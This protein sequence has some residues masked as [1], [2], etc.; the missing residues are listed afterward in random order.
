M[1]V[2]YK[3]PG[4]GKTT[5]LIKMCEQDYGY[6]VCADMRQV[7]MVQQMAMEMGCKIPYPTTF[8]TFLSG[9]Y[10]APGVKKFYIDDADWLISKLA[11]GNEVKAVT[12]SD[13]KNWHFDPMK[14]NAELG[15]RWR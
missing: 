12:M 13:C 1:E 11:R 2:I 5:E 8:E 4:T 7:K 15:A 10:Y 14:A 3:K 6:I 9:K